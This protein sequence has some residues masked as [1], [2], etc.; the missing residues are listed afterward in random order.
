MKQHISLTVYCGT[1]REGPGIEPQPNHSFFANLFSPFAAYGRLG[2]GV[3]FGVGRK[4]RKASHETEVFV[5]LE[6]SYEC[7]VPLVF[8]EW[9][10]RLTT[11]WQ[12]TNGTNTLFHGICIL[13]YR[14]H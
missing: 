1:F 9:T 11:F 3:K 2:L 12:A 5:Q 10:Y 14:E 13:I 6:R 7:E 8:C 4:G